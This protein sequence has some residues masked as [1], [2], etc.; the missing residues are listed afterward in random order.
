LINVTKISTLDLK[1]EIAQIS[2][3]GNVNQIS[4]D[5]NIVVTYTMS[6]ITITLVTD[7]LYNKTDIESLHDISTTKIENHVFFQLMHIILQLFDF[8]Y[9]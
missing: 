2:N 3:D 8:E 9:Y 4:A 1:V 7:P 6:V 5:D